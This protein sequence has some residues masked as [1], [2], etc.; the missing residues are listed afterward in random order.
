MI[1]RKNQPKFRPSLTI[2]DM[3]DCVAALDRNNPNAPALTILR[4]QLA[5]LAVTNPA[6]FPSNQANNLAFGGHSNIPTE[7]FTSGNNQSM[8]TQTGYPMNDLPLP[9]RELKEELYIHVI[10]SGQVS[11]ND[12]EYVILRAIDI[13]IINN[14][15]SYASKLNMPESALSILCPLASKPEIEL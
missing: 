14:L 6:L 12:S 10:N 9:V 15:A 1:D 8:Q 13:Q 3:I 7:A 5:K 4:Q 11:A 2:G